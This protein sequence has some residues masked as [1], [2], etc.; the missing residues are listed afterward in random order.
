MAKT[1]VMVTLTAAQVDEV[2]LFR[3]LMRRQG[4]RLTLATAVVALADAQLETLI[5]E[6]E[7]QPDD[8]DLAGS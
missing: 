3:R 5:S 2:E 4:R 7:L 6:G 1:Q 8:D